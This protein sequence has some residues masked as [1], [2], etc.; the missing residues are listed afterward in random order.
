MNTLND[1]HRALQN[2]IRIGQVFDVDLSLTPPS[3]RVRA[4]D[5]ETDWIAW[6][7]SRAA[8]VSMWAAPVIGETVLM[9][10]PSGDT[11]GAIIVASL[12]SSEHPTL[13]RSGDV[14]ALHVDDGTV[15]RYDRAA[16]QLDATVNGTANI[17]AKAIKLTG[18]VTI[19]GAVTM[20]KTLNVK[21]NIASQ[22]DVKAGSISLKGHTHGGVKGG[23]DMTGA[24]Q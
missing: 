8:A 7:A 23:P 24:P 2:L 13:E 16:H 18:P 20:T 5:L 4:G 12:Y 11:A 14:I 17:K 15:I 10:A 1:I 3:V 19:D 22:A 9:L 21:G 6:S